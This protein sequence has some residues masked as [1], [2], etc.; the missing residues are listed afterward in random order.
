M[1]IH[2]SL[3]LAILLV[4]TPSAVVLSVCIGVGG[5]LCIVSLRSWR[6]GMDSPQL[7]KRDPSSASSADDMIDL[8]I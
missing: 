3:L 5:C 7:T 1:S 8:M 2:L 4:T 6:T